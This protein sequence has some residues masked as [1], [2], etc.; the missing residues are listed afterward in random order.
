[1]LP[2]LNVTSKEIERAAELIAD[3]CAEMDKTQ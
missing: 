3:A 2:P 1:M